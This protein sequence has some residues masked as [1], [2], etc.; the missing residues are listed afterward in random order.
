MGYMNTVLQYGFE[1]FCKDASAL[2]IDGLILPD[3]PMYEFET[4]YRFH[5]KKI[6]P[7]FYIFSNAGNI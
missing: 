7:R 3:L 2:G 4:E 5:H 1:K 6:Q